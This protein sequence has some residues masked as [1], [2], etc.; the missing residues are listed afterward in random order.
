MSQRAPASHAASRGPSRSP[1]GRDDSSPGHHL[2]LHNSNDGRQEHDTKGH[3]EGLGRPQPVKALGVHNILNP[4]DSRHMA[5][6]E[7]GRASK[8]GSAA[9]MMAAARAFSGSRP[10]FPAPTAHGSHPGTPIGNMA[11]LGRPH[12]SGRSSPVM[13]Y[14]YGAPSDARKAASPRLPRTLSFGQPN[15][16]RDV[17]ARRPP[18]L[19]TCSPAKRS[20]E[21]AVAD[22]GRQ[23]P[24]LHHSTGVALP[25]SHGLV[26]PPSTLAQPTARLADAHAPYAPPRPV[27]SRE[28]HGRLHSLP[29]HAHFQQVGVLSRPMSSMGG[30]EEGTSWSEVMR[31]SA[32]G[33]GMGPTEG[34]QAFMTLPGSDTPI[35]VQVDYSQASK[36]ADEKRQRNA[37]ASTRHRRKKKTMQE[38]NMR[39]LQDLK[40]ERQQMAMEVDD[41]KRQRDFYR[42][43]RNRLRDIVARTPGIHQHAAGP[44][45][46]PL[47]S[48][49]RLE[50][51]SPGSHSHMA[52]PTPGY[53]SDQSSAERPA[54][55]RRTEERPEYGGPMFST[56]AGGGPTAG[57]MTGL[58]GGPMY[59][60]PPRPLSAASSASGER[61]PPL[62]AMDGAGPSPGQGVAGSVPQEQDP[63]TGQWRPAHPRQYETGWATAPRKPHEGHSSPW[64]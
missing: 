45:S 29:A 8:E 34:Q 21:A 24:G 44:P 62:R 18:P 52:T 7:S 6:D 48:A 49:E 35:P 55:R 50:D 1:V 3:A 22:D 12:S 31:R 32:M 54:Q 30:P 17:D 25:T 26:T 61:L 38:E 60:V 11:T 51:R 36:K 43:E 41:V 20:Y 63:R 16:P 2:A 28:A 58:A 13:T 37:K 10:Y 53:S 64:Q 57:M 47:R 15:A 56:A 46:P 4:S 23:L 9:P 40:D 39:L 14:P 27:T 33:S 5:P 59:G 42:E 19:G